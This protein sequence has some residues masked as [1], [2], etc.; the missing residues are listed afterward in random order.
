MRQGYGGRQRD[1]VAA[2]QR[3]FHARTALRDAVAHRRHP[4]R[5]LRRGAGIRRAAERIASG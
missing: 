5:D 2:E 3:E 1:D 4:A